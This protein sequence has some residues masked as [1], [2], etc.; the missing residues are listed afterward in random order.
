[1]KSKIG[2]TP[3][4]PSKDMYQAVI[5]TDLK[6]MVRLV[7]VY[8]GLT[9]SMV[10]KNFGEGLGASIKKLTGGRKDEELSNK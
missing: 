6:M 9:M 4:K 2:K 5:D 3:A 8:S 10:R 1:M 7:I